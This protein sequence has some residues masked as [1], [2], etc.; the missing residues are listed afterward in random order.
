MKKYF[1]NFNILK[2][3]NSLAENINTKIANSRIN[4]FRS[5]IIIY[6]VIFS[7][8]LF[9][10]IPG[11][12]NY[13]KY[14]EEIKKVFINDFNMFVSIEGDIEYRFVPS[15][16]LI[17]KTTEINL[18]SKENSNIGKIENI[19]LFISLYELYKN[20]KIEVKKMQ[21]KYANF[22][23]K[24]RIFALFNNHLEKSVIKP[25][26]ILSSNF[27]YI[28]NDDEVATISPINKIEYYIDL[29]TKE[30]KFK[31]SGN[32][33]DI[34]FNFLWKKNYN[35]PLSSIS[36]LAFK[37]PNLRIKHKKTKNGNNYLGNLEF[38]FL[39]RNGYLNYIYEEN[40]LKVKTT[41]KDFSD[42]ILDGEISINPF[43]FNLVLSIKDQ[44]LEYIIDKFISRL[45]DYKD[46]LHENFN[47]NIKINL[48]NIKNPF[49]K[50]GIVNLSFQ[51]SR[52]EIQN[53]FQIKKIGSVKFNNLNFEQKNEKVYI[54]CDVL[55]N[56]KD[57][58][59]FF[60]RFSISK[61]NKID[62][63]KISLK[64]S[65]NIDTEDYYLSNVIINENLK[66]EENSSSEFFRSYKFSNIQQLRR[67]IRNEF[68]NF[69]LE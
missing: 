40:I 46:S 6:A 44:N 50:S 67:I 7:I 31:L 38:N 66:N 49:V 43:F 29:K 69:N 37:N 18:N 21:I 47:G 9:L 60:R 4:N 65:K 12:F 35:F 23:F 33:F 57:K 52:F 63:K 62:L 51:N 42:L 8:F 13:E 17:L 22:Y 1:K 16:H 2:R 64:I 5:V 25:I 19:K 54:N 36:E 10:S 39:R 14:K 41:K 59:E 15:P 34:N 28:N 68:V 56:I 27:F 48:T 53:E 11:L 61:G 58:D 55:I 30:K 24:N 32:L 45:Y 3:F 20:K 26:E